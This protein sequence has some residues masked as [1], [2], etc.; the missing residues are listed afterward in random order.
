MVE[1]TPPAIDQLDPVTPAQVDAAR[2]ACATYA[3]DA[4]DLAQLLAVVGIGPG[5]RSTWRGPVDAPGAP[6]RS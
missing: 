4:A 6:S 1:K 3:R 2:M 5:W